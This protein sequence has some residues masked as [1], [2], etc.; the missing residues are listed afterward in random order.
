MFILIIA[1]LLLFVLSLVLIMYYCSKGCNSHWKKTVSIVFFLLS[2][3]LFSCTCILA[4]VGMQHGIPLLNDYSVEEMVE[5]SIVSPLDDSD[6]VKDKIDSGDFHGKVIFYRADC[7][8]C[9][10]LLPDKIEKYNNSQ[11]VFFVSTRSE[12]GSILKKDAG[13]KSVPTAFEYNGKWEKIELDSI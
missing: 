12:K 8:D 10:E 1:S 4:E 3:L 7:E 9:H 11:D 6:Y 13:V 2:T 5:Y